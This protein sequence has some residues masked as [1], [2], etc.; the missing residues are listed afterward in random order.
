VIS[1]SS[2]VVILALWTL[3][4]LV[5]LAVRD[6]SIADLLWGVGFV[7]VAGVTFAGAGAAT[8]RRLLVVTLTAIWGLR[9]TAYLS[10]RNVGKGEDYRYQTMRRALG[11]RFWLVSLMSVFVLQGL[12][13]W[14]VSLPVQA[15]ILA[16]GSGRL[17]V[18]DGV[19]FALWAIGLFFEAV[20]D[21]QLARFK[22]DPASK[23]Q[24]MDR[25][26]WR[27]TRHPNYF[28]DC[29]VWWGLY[30]LALASGAWWSAIGAIFM[31]LLLLR[32]SGVA[33]LERTIVHRRPAYADY[34]ARTSAFVP[35]PPR[36]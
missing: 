15:A 11:R 16:R 2:L 33:L 6:A 23:G 36:R 24:V 26:L 1:L 29:M 13:L 17:G 10:W 20:G 21:W 35:W 5:S 14:V 25:G 8:P 34:V 32:V 31:T 18:L 28:G 27:Y 4:W 22:R 3:V 9:L 30:A 19:G 7:V 12:L